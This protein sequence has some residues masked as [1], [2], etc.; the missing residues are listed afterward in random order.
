[1]LI[2]LDEF[3]EPFN[4]QQSEKRKVSFFYFFKPIQYTSQFPVL[5]ELK[6]IF[7]LLCEKDGFVSLKLFSVSF[8]I[9]LFLYQK[10]QFLPF[11]D[12]SILVQ[13]VVSF[14]LIK[15][16]ATTTPFWSFKKT[17]LIFNSLSKNWSSETGANGDPFFSSPNRQ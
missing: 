2:F 7:F 1:M 5:A 4:N 6:T 14:P 17:I 15:F 11:L 13:V 16:N 12:Y 9:S 10:G 3:P 8:C